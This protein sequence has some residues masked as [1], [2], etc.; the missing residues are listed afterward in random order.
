ME[1]RYMEKEMESG[2]K[3]SSLSTKLRHKEEELRQKEAAHQEEISTL[4][5]ELSDRNAEESQRLTAL[6]QLFAQKEKDLQAT[7]ASLGEDLKRLINERDDCFREI[8]ELT[9]R[10]SHLS[11]KDGEYSKELEILR[12]EVA[13]IKMS[14][15]EYEEK[16]RL[17]QKSLEVEKQKSVEA[18]NKVICLEKELAR[19]KENVLIIEDKI[20]NV[21]SDIGEKMKN[22]ELSFVEK[23]SEYEKQR[24]SMEGELRLKD[25]KVRELEKELSVKLQYIHELEV[26]CDELKSKAAFNDSE[27]MEKIADFGKML[28]EK[29]ESIQELQD[30]LVEKETSHK[31]QMHFWETECTA[32]KKEISERDKVIEE[33]KQKCELKENELSSLTTG[34]ATI[35]NDL[36]KRLEFLNTQLLHETAS[37]EKDQSSLE[38]ALGREKIL[39]AEVG[40][41]KNEVEELRLQ[42]K[43]KVSELE[44][45]SKENSKLALELNN[46]HHSWKTQ[47]NELEN[48]KEISK[49][50]D[51]KLQI[52]KTEQDQKT[53]KQRQELDIALNK[54]QQL[55]VEMSQKDSLIQEVHIDNEKFVK[56]KQAQM[57][58]LIEEKQIQYLEH[59]QKSEVLVQQSER[60][61]QNK[62]AELARLKMEL[63]EK[64]VLLEKQISDR[65]EMN[66]H[67]QSLHSQIQTLKQDVE[68]VS[69]KL[70]FKTSEALD[71]QQEIQ[72]LVEERDKMSS[73]IERLEKQ[74]AEQHH[75]IEMR[76][77]EQKDNQT[78]I[79][80]KQQE[81]EQAK[82][83]LQKCLQE[84]ETYKNTV[85]LKE[86]EFT[87]QNQKYR[88]MSASLEELNVQYI[89]QNSEYKQ[90]ESK[91]TN[92][93]LQLVDAENRYRELEAK[94]ASLEMQL[95]ESFAQTQHAEKV[96]RMKKEECQQ[97][98]VKL[99]SFSKDFE[100]T[101]L[102]I[103]ETEKIFI[104]KQKEF[105]HL[106]SELEKVVKECDELKAV[107]TERGKVHEETFGKFSSL[108]LQHEQLKSESSTWQGKFQTHHAESESE[109]QNLKQKLSNVEEALREGQHQLKSSEKVNIDLK[110]KL[111][112]AEEALKL[113]EENCDK[114]KEQLRSAEKQLSETNQSIIKLNSKIS[115][116]ENAIHEKE[117]FCRDSQNDFDSL[118]QKYSDVESE[119]QHLRSQLNFSQQM[120]ENSQILRSNNEE[121]LQGICLTLEETRTKLTSVENKLSDSNASCE[122]LL[123]QLEDCQRCLNSSQEAAK[124]Y[125]DQ[126][127]SLNENLEQAIEENKDL[128]VKN[129]RML[130]QQ[131]DNEKL[132]KNQVLELEV[133]KEQISCLQKEL[134][135]TVAS[136]EK[137]SANLV[138][139]EQNHSSTLAELENLRKNMD[140][141]ILQSNT[142]C[143]HLESLCQ[144]LQEEVNSK[145]HSIEVLKSSEAELT[146]SISQLQQDNTLLK[147]ELDTI[148]ATVH[149]DDSYLS[150]LIET[151]QNISGKL[152]QAEEK[153]KESDK[154]VMLLEQTVIK[155]N[156][157]KDDYV[158]QIKQLKD[159]N[160]QLEVDNTAL[161]EKLNDAT[162]QIKNIRKD[163]DKSKTTF[164][165]HISELSMN[166]EEAE[167]LLKETQTD[168]VEKSNCI[169]KM[170]AEIADLKTV[171]CQIDYLKSQVSELER[172]RNDLLQQ[173]TEQG[174][175]SEK[176]DIVNE[177]EIF[178]SLSPGLHAEPKTQVDYNDSTELRNTFSSFEDHCGENGM[179]IEK[180]M[181]E[182]ENYKRCDTENQEKLHNLEKL[183][184]EMREKDTK[185]SERVCALERRE[186][187]LLEQMSDIETTVIVPLETENQ[188]LKDEVN[189][190]KQER[191]DAQSRINKWGDEEDDHQDLE[192]VH[193]CLEDALITRDELEKKVEILS[194]DISR[195]EQDKE[196]FM[197]RI[198]DLETNE[199]EYKDKIEALEDE[200]ERLHGLEKTTS[201]VEETET[202]LIDRVLDLEEKEQQLLAELAELKNKTLKSATDQID[203]QVSYESLSERVKYLEQKNAVL[204]DAEGR[205]MDKI[206]EL[207][208]IQ[209]RLQ[210]KIQNLHS[211]SGDSTDSASVE[212][213]VSKDSCFLQMQNSSGDSDSTLSVKN[214]Q[215]YSM[216]LS[217]NTADLT[218]TSEQTIN[219]SDAPSY[220]NELEI[221]IRNLTAS[222][223]DKTSKL[224]YLEEKCELLR[225]SE[226]RLMEKL[227]ENEHAENRK[228]SSSD[229]KSDLQQKLETL[230]EENEFLAESVEN[231][232]QLYKEEKEKTND[233]H[234]RLLENSS[235]TQELHDTKEELKATQKMVEEIQSEYE[236]QLSEREELEAKL[237]NLLAQS[238]QRVS[239]LQT[240]LIALQKHEEDLQRYNAAVQ[241]GSNPQDIAK[242]IEHEKTEAL[243]KLEAELKSNYHQHEE[244]FQKQIQFL[245]QQQ[246]KL[247]ADH[248]QLEADHKSQLEDIQHSRLEL[249]QQVNNLKASELGLQMQ[250]TVL[251]Q[252][253]HDLLNQVDRLEKQLEEMKDKAEV[254][255]EVPEEESFQSDSGMSA[256]DQR[257][258]YVPKI[259]FLFTLYFLF[260]L[261]MKQTNAI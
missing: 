166:K 243:Q 65:N 190:I 172:D 171:C 168:L 152:Y 178:V 58:L 53:E 236:E 126:V 51:Y 16:I 202:C 155:I 153:V 218:H 36:R 63:D 13:S 212:T 161:Q 232:K 40:A 23:E 137:V 251:M 34:Q 129:E 122:S 50:T 78:L 66:V 59:V 89:K 228:T 119:C 46:L 140:S 164:E 231:Y 200:V 198:V 220:I 260:V 108:Q 245:Q 189:V 37:K 88:Q 27:T 227:L 117:S 113:S 159:K 241:D 130:Q 82:T 180:L 97:L 60:E 188:E 149:S 183:L 42:L 21:K 247:Q 253:E 103:Q 81:L 249:Q 91:V 111:Y 6:E 90:L 80:S 147:A 61:S 110:E 209:Q 230:M 73:D 255:C 2:K 11:D 219:T 194:A 57:E 225:D 256:D 257:T 203:G 207:E 54:I 67:M 79:S 83:E 187:E 124:L 204:Q 125:K 157:E 69:Q 170:E 169:V 154:K 101:S 104:I 240:Q 234:D 208:E 26:E 139:C 3:I 14:E 237:G 87:E 76:Y 151:N 250:V 33:L 70:A 186:K 94:C 181:S 19:E 52:Q 156:S 48:I 215:N 93:E 98:E 28:V 32:L 223:T 163:F 121:K 20:I 252:R 106:E 96:I 224:Q 217:T 160:R 138:Q 132:Y 8:Q 179:N 12:C 74:I 71:Y 165:S 175:R 31:E 18:E 177:S 85:H 235:I 193:K 127:N 211:S 116:L 199:S 30:C 191:D 24:L 118:K 45:K 192:T 131:A 49:Q 44:N 195:L 143:S 114:F 62:D 259:F 102:Q 145:S 182:I 133:T 174:S 1:V 38:Q 213:A 95:Q 142:K 100:A 72:K 144:T 134:I 239:D 120:A 68:N 84:I 248:E 75:E 41:L 55:E 4:Q 141:I 167:K 10:N 205:Y 15:K 185:M 206:V 162:I 136:Y 9:E 196:S 47:Q 233:L 135:Q 112:I 77:Y 105:K 242:L 7:I 246:Q 214:S 35:E 25:E 43:E 146:L 5:K 56:E 86:N 107:L 148:S 128:V 258:R 115:T 92:A 22:I 216:S 29:N 210:S 221:Q 64:N 184:K 197:K 238:Q 222:C 39:S 173:L 158:S 201:L 123:S 109:V 254:T 17:L 244:E 99:T 226:A 176:T 261:S 150:E 229:N